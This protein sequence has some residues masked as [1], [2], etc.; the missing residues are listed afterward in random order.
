[1]GIVGDV[2]LDFINHT[3]EHVPNKINDRVIAL[4]I[5]KIKKIRNVIGIAFGTRKAEITK[6]VLRGK[7]VNILIVDKNLAE[8]VVSEDCRAIPCYETVF[9]AF[10]L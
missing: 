9:G 7:I 1:M 10:A 3:G 4:P 6:A 5:S 2:N 8:S